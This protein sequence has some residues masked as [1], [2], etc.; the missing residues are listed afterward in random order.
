MMDQSNLTDRLAHLTKKRDIKLEELTDQ[1]KPGL[2]GI[3]ANT[4]NLILAAIKKIQDAPETYGHCENCGKA[5]DLERRQSV[6][7]AQH[8]R[9]CFS[10]E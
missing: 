8:C 2:A 3:W 6:P 9:S 1:S 10:K 7:E 4:L 5:I